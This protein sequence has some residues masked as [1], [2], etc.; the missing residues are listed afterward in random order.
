[1]SQQQGDPPE[2][3]HRP[4]IDVTKALHEA[5]HETKDLGFEGVPDR[6]PVEENAESI[7]QAEQAED[8]EDLAMDTGRYGLPRRP[9]R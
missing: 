5:G 8:A 7:A 2:E 9:D 3:T 4:N 1:M 6:G